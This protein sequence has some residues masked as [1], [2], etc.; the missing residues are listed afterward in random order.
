[1]QLIKPTLSKESLTLALCD[2]FPNEYKSKQFV[3]LTL[4]QIL[5][6]LDSIDLEVAKSYLG[7]SA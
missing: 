6:R 3:G 7:I 1:M 2:C 4:E 5:A